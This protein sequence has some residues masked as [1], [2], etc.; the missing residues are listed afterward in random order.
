MILT[1]C[2]AEGNVTAICRRYKFERFIRSL[3]VEHSTC[4]G[5]E[6]ASS[7]CRKHWRSFSEKAYSCDVR[8]TLL[9]EMAKGEGA[10]LE[11]MKTVAE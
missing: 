7:Q 9:E 10:M 6:K 2:S 8:M 3:D 11:F 4:V 1:K 5:Q